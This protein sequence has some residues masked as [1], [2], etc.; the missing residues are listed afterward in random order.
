M[1]TVQTLTGI[2]KLIPAQKL[3]HAGAT[4]LRASSART[5]RFD[6][7]DKPAT[8]G[9][10]RVK[11]TDMGGGTYRMQIFRVE[12]V[13]AIGGIQPADLAAVICKFTGIA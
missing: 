4:N 10:R 7:P 8:D 3:A 6:I 13:D 1:T 5:V 2:L 11:V 12:E 9:F